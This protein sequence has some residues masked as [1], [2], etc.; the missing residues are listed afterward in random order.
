VPGVSQTLSGCDCLVLATSQVLSVLMQPRL[1]S[2]SSQLSVAFTVPGDFRAGGA[3][4]VL[5]LS[6]KVI[7]R[8]VF[9]D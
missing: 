3:L 9:P 7:A 8:A 4:K 5:A 6:V 2:S 1:V